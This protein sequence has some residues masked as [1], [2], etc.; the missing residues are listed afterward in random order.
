MSNLATI[1]NNILA[2][3]GIDDLNVVVTTGSYANPA[4][5]TSL[6]WSKITGAPLGDYL[7][8]AGGTMTGN[9]NWAQTDRGITWNF[10]TDG[11]YIKFYNTGDGDTDSRLEFATIDNNNEYF[12]WGHVPSG[13]SFYES[14][15]LV[16]NSSGNAQLIVSGSVAIGTTSPS[17]VFHAVSSNTTIGAFRNSGA[18][19]G[20]LL[21]GN[22]AG[23]LALRILASGDAI[24]FSDVSKYLAFG[25]NGGSERMRIS[26]AGAIRFNT[27]GSGSYTGTVAYNLAVDSSGN[28]IETAGGVVDGSGTTNYIPKWSDPNTLT[29]SIIYDSGTNVGIGTASPSSKLDVLGNISATRIILNN[30]LFTNVA[31]YETGAGTWGG[32]YNFN[33]NNGS[34]VHQLTGGLSGVWYNTGSIQ[35]YVN[36]GQTAN[37]VAPERMRLTSAGNLGINTSNPLYKLQ[38]VTD[39]VAGR[40]NMANISRT[41]GNWVRF[42]NPQYSADASMGLLLRVFPDSD[43]RQGAG[44]IASGG[45]NNATTDLDLFVTTSPDGLGGTSYSAIKIKGID[46]AVGIGTTAPLRKLHVVGNFA[47]NNSG[48][49]YYGVNITGGEGANPNILIGDWHNA[50]ANLKWDSAGRFLRIDSQYSTSGAPIVFSGNDA[51]TEYMRITAAGNVGIGYSNPDYPLTV[52]S[53]N[54]GGVGANLG[55]ILS[56]VINTAIPSSSVKA[57]IGVTNSGFGYSAGSLLIQPRTGVSAAIAFATEGTEKVRIDSSGFV[58]IANTSPSYLLDVGNTSGGS[59]TTIRANNGFT[60]AS[61]GSQLLLGNSANFT[62][63][64]FRLNGGG[65]SS[66]AGIGS[67]NI[68]VTQSVP[69]AFY[70]SNGERMRII[71]SGE[72]GIGTSSPAAL[73]NVA[74][75]V[76]LGNSST[77]T[78]SLR[79]TRTSTAILADAHYFTATANTPVQSWIEGGYMTGE[80]SGAITAPNSGYP[81]YE[82]YAGQGAST[83]KAFGFINKTSGTFTSVDILYAMFLKRTGQVQ[84]AKYGIGTFTGTVAY[85]LAVDSSGNIIETAGG[86]VDGSGTTNYVPKWSDPNTLTNSIIYDSGTNIGI[87]TTA[88]GARL[89]VQTSTIS[90]ADSLRITD[91]TGVI[92]IGHWDTIT[93]RFEFSGKPTYFVQYGAGNYISFGTLGSENMRIVSGGNVGLGTTTP[94]RKLHV[95]GG[96]G[97][98]QIQSTSTSSMMY[99]GD[100]N[101]SVV[102]NQGIGSVGN[103]LWFMTG[104]NERMRITSAGLVGIGASAPTS[105]LSVQGNT[106]LGNSYG[107]TTSST[108]TTRIS[109]YA[110]RYDASNRYGDYGVLIL[111]SDSG[112]TASARR[113][114]LTNGVNAN[115]FAIIRSVDANTDPALGDGGV[116]SSGSADF[117]ITNTGGVEIANNLLVNSS[118]ASNPGTIR[119]NSSNGNYY[120]EIAAQFNIQS[121][122][123]AFRGGG[124]SGVVISAQDYG[125]ATAIWSNN[126]EKIRITD[127]GNVG[128]GTTSPSYKL[129]VVGSIYSS[130]NLTTAG[131]VTIGMSPA[132]FWN[133][134]FADY[135]DGSG[136]YIGSVQ[137]GGYKSISGDSYYFNSGNWYSDNTVSSI[138]SLISGSIRFYTNSGLTANTNFTP[139]E[140]MRITDAGNVGIGNTNPGDFSGDANTLVLGS[141]GTTLAGMTIANNTT[142]TGGI[143]FA[144]GTDGTNKE[145]RGYF[146]YYHGDDS[147]TIGAGGAGRVSITATAT[148]VFSG[149][150][151]VDTNT[152]FVD[153]AGNRVGIG[154]ATPSASYKLD[155]NGS[156]QATAYYESSDLR[157]KQILNKHEGVDFGAI[158]YRWADARDA[159]LH[160]GYAA[161]EVQKWLPDAVNENENGYLTLDYNQAHTYKIAML[162][163]RIAELEKQLKNK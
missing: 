33:L 65:N 91:G 14:M 8:L 88:P 40:Q 53:I 114:M 75:S 17:Y 26:S 43:S 129:H 94:L 70:T 110:L 161:Q 126:T 39:A 130:S 35:W 124:G 113:F 106:N 22:T 141:T 61:D 105:T 16:P 143:Y 32:G 83:A 132:P 97:T 54:L 19:N 158:E 11:A 131:S 84:F 68:G 147:L 77:T 82:E 9:I 59:F 96:A 157:L 76:Q 71:S 2:D 139:S 93:N 25:T 125:S 121:G 23:D 100:T 153:A 4:W 140:R 64:Y 116:I 92:N 67:L 119:I 95:V 66:Q 148:D 127:A 3:S 50:S 149:N 163:K 34:P 38:V 46:G 128:I 51:A 52:S 62:N 13:G 20:Q 145:Y 86:V 7:P 123:L 99:F 85:N 134:K 160:W 137:A 45:A 107:N 112:W 37:T 18:A 146:S 1:S 89:T 136:L 156:V 29:N 41:T 73:L 42:T 6:A 115:R 90:S 21:V 81:Y 15:K 10:N 28:I 154:T 80:R 78:I 142:G 58:G 55:I 74:G 48:S 44:I 57:Q 60:G 117:V 69:M 102:D 122:Y 144:D 108:S 109:G 103:S 151:I 63:A 87:G 152:L 12:R 138:V 79:L 27:Y 5:I 56:N 162:E 104:G 150:F 30:A 111:S 49:E 133:A 31:Q 98:V 118:S 120:T 47:V 155:V 24:I 135:S 72:I 159:K 36:D 101:S